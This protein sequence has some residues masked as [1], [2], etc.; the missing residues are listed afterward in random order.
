VIEGEF[1][2]FLEISRELPELVVFYNAP[3]CGAS[4]PDH[5]H[6]QAGSLGFMPIESELATIKSK[7]GNPLIASSDLKL[8]SVDDGLRRF[9]VLE[10]N[11]A[12]SLDKIFT[13]VIRFMKNQSSDQEPMLNML[14]YYKQGWQLLIFPREK[15]RPWQFFEEGEAN[16]LLSP[17]AVDMGGSL[18]TPL[19]KD[20]KKITKV[21]IVDIFSQIS[22]NEGTFELLKNYL[23]KA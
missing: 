10:S 8:I 12:D 18:I 13:R 11:K 5:M 2:R 7:Y 20:F 22:L 16:I 23:S 1:L 15:H 4:A 19:E 21:D 9:L 14:C 3:N 6:F 17:A